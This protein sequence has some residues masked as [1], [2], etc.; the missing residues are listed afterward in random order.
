MRAGRKI[1]PDAMRKRPPAA[2][3]WHGADGKIRRYR[4]RRGPRW[5]QIVI[6]GIDGPRNVS[7][8]LDRLRR[9]LSVYFRGGS[10]GD[11]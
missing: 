3:K 6:D 9:H 8:L 1:A 7:W 4:L 5:G 2:V 10:Q 11:L